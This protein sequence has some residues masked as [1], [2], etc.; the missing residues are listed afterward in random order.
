MSIANFATL[1]LQAGL[2]AAAVTLTL[3]TWRGWSWDD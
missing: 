2:V 3:A 1:G